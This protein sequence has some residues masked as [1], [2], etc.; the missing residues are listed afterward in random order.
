M[1]TS[2]LGHDR[3]SQNA[4]QEL[5]PCST[6]KW[7]MKIITID[8]LK[9]LQI[10]RDE[11]ASVAVECGLLTQELQ[12]DL[13]QTGVIGLQEAWVINFD[14]EYGSKACVLPSKEAV[15]SVKPLLDELRLKNTVLDLL[16]YI[17]ERQERDKSSV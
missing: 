10:T 15:R 12:E 14:G 7:S 2:A 9:C 1:S 6:N 13:L 17:H 16:D 8:G 3:R 4:M 5:R 11:W